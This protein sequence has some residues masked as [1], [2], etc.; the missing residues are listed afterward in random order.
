[1]AQ[2]RE[3]EEAFGERGLD[4]SYFLAEIL[5]KSF[6]QLS[7]GLSRLFADDAEA[8]IELGEYLLRGECPRFYRF[9]DFRLL[10]VL[11]DL[12][13]NLR[14]AL[15]PVSHITEQH[16]ENFSWVSYWHRLSPSGEYV[17]WGL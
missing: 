13:I 12:L 16:K 4:L 1:M 14:L 17:G 11:T 7:R 10:R 9:L 8:L 2:F 3:Y 15:G 6:L 5:Q